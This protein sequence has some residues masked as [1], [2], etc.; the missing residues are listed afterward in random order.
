MCIQK[1]AVSHAA[2]GV[3]LV[4]AGRFFWSTEPFSAGLGSGAAP[5]P[6]KPRKVGGGE[7]NGNVVVEGAVNDDGQVEM[8]HGMCVCACVCVCMYVYMY[9]SC[10]Y[11]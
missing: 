3:C 11:I 1:E 6:E 2:G 7:L 9:I 8:S 10:I 4:T 5:A